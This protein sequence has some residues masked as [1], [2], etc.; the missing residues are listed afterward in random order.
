MTIA[1][2]M[3][4]HVTPLKASTRK[5]VIYTS[6]GARR[7][8]NGLLRGRIICIGVKVIGGSVCLCDA[9]KHTLPAGG[10]RFQFLLAFGQRDGNQFSPEVGQKERTARGEEMVNVRYF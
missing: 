10:G 2:I 6:G 9:I 4:A 1:Y 5:M 3:A 8:E 7:A